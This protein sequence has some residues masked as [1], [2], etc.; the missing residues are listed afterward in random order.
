MQNPLRAILVSLATATTLIAC[1]QTEQL[2][3]RVVGGTTTQVR[4]VQPSTGFLP[5]PDL[6]G[7]GGSKEAALVY[8]RPDVNSLR[9]AKSFSIQ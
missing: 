8:R 1:E 6:L 4:D 7:P 9:T 2:S 3:R 5:R